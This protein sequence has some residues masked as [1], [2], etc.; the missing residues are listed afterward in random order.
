MI[1][2]CLEYARKLP[3]GLE[4]LL[5]HQAEGP[6]IAKPGLGEVFCAAIGY[7]QRSVIFKFL[8][9]WRDR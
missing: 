9:R 6:F 8:N 1:S 3:H 4:R 2:R 5:L 7:L